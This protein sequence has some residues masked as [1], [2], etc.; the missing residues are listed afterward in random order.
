MVV[1]VV[2]PLQSESL[3][4]EQIILMARLVLLGD[5]QCVVWLYTLVVAFDVDLVNI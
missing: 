3:K 5:F 4:N 1:I 2:P